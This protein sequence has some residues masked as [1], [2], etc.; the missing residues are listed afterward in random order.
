ML[1]PNCHGT[2]FVLINGQPVPCPECGGMGELHCC[3]GL[4]EQID[5]AADVSDAA[6][7]SNSTHNTGKSNCPPRN[8]R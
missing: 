4:Q 8:N 3:D 2:R 1:C 5:P 7:S 6:A